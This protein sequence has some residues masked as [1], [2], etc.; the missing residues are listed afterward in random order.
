M[1]GIKMKNRPRSWEQR[2]K[3]W[4]RREKRHGLKQLV[5]EA[6][7]AYNPR[8]PEPFYKEFMAML[9][10]KTIPGPDLI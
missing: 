4:L 6:G 7:P 1:S 5:I 9:R 3:R 8:F 2:Y 10:A